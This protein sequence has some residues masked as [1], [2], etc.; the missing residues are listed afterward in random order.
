MQMWNNLK[1]VMQQFLKVKRASNYKQLVTDML[2]AFQ[3]LGCR[4]GVKM[5][6]LP[7][8]LDYFPDNCGKFREKQGKCFHQEISAMDERYQGQWNISMITDHC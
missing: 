5:H 4:M 7:S 3:K 6:F 8:H 1:A 2:I